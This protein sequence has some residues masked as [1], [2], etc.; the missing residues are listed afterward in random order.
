M[1]VQPEDAGLLE[2]RKHLMP[3]KTPVP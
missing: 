2:V 1:F 3:S